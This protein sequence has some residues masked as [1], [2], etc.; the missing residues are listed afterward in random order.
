MAELGITA[1]RA[2]GHSSKSSC[3]WRRIHA[4]ISYVTGVATSDTSMGPERDDEIA[5][6]KASIA[7]RDASIVSKNALIAILEEKL[8]LATHRQFAPR[9]EK[10]ASLGQHELLFNEA[11]ALGTKPESETEASEI[12][13]PAHARPRGKR[14]PI[15]PKLPRKRIEHDIAEAE[16]TCA[17]GCRLTRIGEVVS[18]QLDIEPAKACVLQHVRFKYACR[19][20]EGASSAAADS[21]AANT[22]SDAHTESASS[23]RGASD[24]DAASASSSRGASDAHAASAP[25]AGRPRGAV[26]TAPLP[27]QPI[28]KSNASPGLLAFITVSKYADGMPLYRLEGIL[29][30]YLI[31]VSRTAMAAWMIRCGELVVP[32]INLFNDILLGY[33]ILQMDETTVQV[34]KEDGRAATAKSFMWVRRGGPPEQPVILFDYAATRAAS[35]PL[36]LLED[37]KGFLQSDGYRGYGAVCRCDGVVHVGCLDHARR[38]FADAVKAQHAI[39]GGEQG[40]APEALVII[41]KLY[42]IEKLARDAKMTAAQR[43]RLRQEKA[44]PIWTELRAWLDKN[45]GAAPPQSLTGKAINYLAAEWPKLVRC[46]DDGRLEISNVLVE[47]AIRPFVVGRKAW[48]FSDTPA[49]A[50]A[51]ARLY[52]IIETAKAAGLEPYA[53][54]RLI[55]EKLPQATTLADIEALLPWNVRAAQATHSVAA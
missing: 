7:E 20:C 4:Q 55:F 44:K 24:A 26:I 16:K 23:S 28:P 35:V 3:V 32:L 38:K 14:K 39:A 10:L 34:L 17:C 2:R 21:D 46:L 18:E 45:L 42:A 15:D 40:L 13:V 22:A 37:Y 53:Y 51:S 30:R 12:V 9:S 29:A 27:A 25:E 1:E 54:L 48:L 49:G 33:D 11:E 6:L 19:T 41:R 36:R 52:S 47:N 31:S 8:R 43:H 5:A 50:H